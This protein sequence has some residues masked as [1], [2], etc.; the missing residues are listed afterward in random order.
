MSLKAQPIVPLPLGLN[1]CL[2]V[3]IVPKNILHLP[4]WQPWGLLDSAHMPPLNGLE[5][6][7]YPVAE[8]DKD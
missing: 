3:D 8:H 4:R 2:L 6:E 1:A 7:G 5:G